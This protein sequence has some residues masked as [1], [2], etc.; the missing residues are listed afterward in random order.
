MEAENRLNRAKKKRGLSSAAAIVGILLIVVAVVLL[1]I[2][3]LLQGKT[4]TTDSQ[5]G[6]ESLKTVTCEAE[7]LDYPFFAYGN[8]DKEETVVKAIFDS[9][10]KLSM[11]ALTQTLYYG[12]SEMMQR[13]ETENNGAMDVAFSQ[14]G[15]EMGALDAKYSKILG[16]FKMSIYAD[17]GKINGRSLKFFLLD[18]LNY[19]D[20]SS[21]QKVSQIYADKGLKCLVNEK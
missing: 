18:E 14:N 1:L 4:T 15:L 2:L 8:A 21:Q 16:A 3:F 19:S 7:G 9:N 17:K 5:N 6:I 13:S 12:D 20:N 11:L 10:D